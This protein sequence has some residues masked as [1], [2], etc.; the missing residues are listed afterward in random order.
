MDAKIET[1]MIPFSP[2]MWLIR[3]RTKIYKFSNIVT[4]HNNNQPNTNTG[5]IWILIKVVEDF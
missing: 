5:N 1:H 2:I 3:G 4:K